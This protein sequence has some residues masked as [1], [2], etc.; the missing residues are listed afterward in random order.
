MKDQSTKFTYLWR[1]WRHCYRSS[2]A[3]GHFLTSSLRWN[4]RTC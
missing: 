3:F 2:F 4:G 1:F